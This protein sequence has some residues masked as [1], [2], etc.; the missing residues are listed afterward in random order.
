MKRIRSF[1]AAAVF[2]GLA[3][4]VNPLAAQHEQ[5]HG[6]RARQ[7]EGMMPGMQMLEAFAPAKLL[8][9]RAMLALTETQI[10]QLQQIEVEVTATGEHA[11]ATH[12]THREQLHSALM[13]AKP[14]PHVVRTHFDTAHAA[15]GH[16]HWQR[17]DA[18]L[19]GM[20]VLTETQQ[21]SV[22]DNSN[23]LR[24]RERRP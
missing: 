18:A 23:R 11:L 5:H 2:L 12:E 3:G 22:R 14:D 6:Q 19:R 4:S 8:E 15:M 10:R 9:Q 24:H 21:Q 17:I 13:A 20:A 7:G 1:L 16:A